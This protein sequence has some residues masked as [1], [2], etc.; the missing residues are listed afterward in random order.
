MRNRLWLGLALAGI[1]AAQVKY[2]D[3]L[4]GPGD[5]W[6]TYAGDYQG[7]RHSPLK[8]ITTANVGSLTPKWAYHVP[9]ASGLRTNPIVYDGVMYVTNTNEMRALDAR[10]GRLIWSFKDSQSKKEG[11]NRGAAIL[12]DRVYFVTADVHLVALDRRT[13][14]VIWQKKYGNVE[15]GLY[16]SA[17]PL[18]LKNLVLV[19]VAGG[20]TG[21]RGYIAALAADTG[22]EKWRTYTIP[23]KGEPGSETWGKYIEYGGGGTW[24]SGTFDPALNLIYWTTGNAWPDFYGENRKGDNLYSSSL[25]ALDPDTGK[26]KWYF[27][28]TPHDTHDWDAQSWPVLIDAQVQGKMRKLVLHA[29]RN[30]FFY[31]LDRVT[32]EYLHSSRLVEKLDWASG[33]DAKGR[34]IVLP[35]TDPTPNGNRTCPGVRGATNWMSPSFNP[36]TGLMYVVTL[37]QCDIFTSSSKEPEPK[38]NFSGGGAGPKPNEIGQFFL[39]AFDPK[40]GLK[41]WEYPMTGPGESWAGTVSTAGNVVFFGDDDGQLVA[42]DARD[43]KH[44]WHFNMGEGLTASPITYAVD[45]KQYVAIASATAIFSFGLHEPMKSVPVPK[46]KVE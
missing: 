24:L 35:G 6:L 1:A 19:G 8:Q 43:G 31:A 26:M 13:G 45:G 34:P 14:A 3:I 42:V 25:L 5:N 40:T 41:K 37:E 44:L 15:D 46:T 10:S 12:G 2:E 29:N 32:G 16:A 20:D 28:F 22:E 9:K 4:K 23:T 7:N 38:K 30:G 11:A 33:I 18:V 21:M 27:Q 17:A 39:R 36:V